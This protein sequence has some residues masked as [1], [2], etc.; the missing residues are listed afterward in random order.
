MTVGRLALLVLAGAALLGGALARAEAEL[1]YRI[2]LQAP[3]AQRPLLEDHLDLYRWRGHER[4]DE[5]QLGRLL[6]QA[7]EQVRSLLASEGFYTPLVHI[8]RQQDADGPL[9]RLDVEPGEPVRVSGIELQLAGPLTGDP[10]QARLARIRSEW[11]L[12]AGRI[13]RHEDWERAKRDALRDLLLDRY[14]AAGVARSQA[15]VDPGRHAVDLSLILDSGPAFSFGPLQVSGLERYPASIVESLNPIR[16]GEPYDQARLLD[17]Q[18]RLQNSPYL[19]GAQVHMDVDP[20]HPDQVPIQVE[21]KER[22]SRTLSLGIGASTDIGPRAQASFQD[23]NLLD[24]ALRLGGT[25]ALAEKEQGMSG[26]LQLPTTRHGFQDS[27]NASFQR[28]D[29][30]GEVTRTLALGARRNR[31]QGRNEIS[32]GLNLYRE[33]QDLA[34]AAGDR[35]SALVASWSLTRRA[36]DD[37]LLPSRGYILNLQADAAAQSL[38]SDQTFIRGYAKLAWFQPLGKGLLILRGEAGGVAADHRH[39]IPSDFLFRT[40]GDQSVRGYDYQSLGVAE[41]GAIVGG[42]WLAVAS[43]EYVHWLAPAWG[44]ATFVDAG[45]AGDSPDDLVPVL[46]YGLGVRWKS[47]VGPLSLD[48]AR[49]RESGQVRMHFSVGYSF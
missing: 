40:G 36:V 12:P 16:P 10:G 27:L 18:T 47:P 45:T 4:L 46:G 30:S 37:P 26:E 39:G 24:R 7:P 32:Y 6:E 43:A 48:L 25:L 20:S 44:A 19:A 31:S 9:I 41:A 15:T 22:P 21:V 35:S 11:G 8:E 29:A 38:L 3:A 34:G 49:G 14:P 33:L 23:L 13:F 17:L 1:P 28:T 5:A 2:Q 42:R